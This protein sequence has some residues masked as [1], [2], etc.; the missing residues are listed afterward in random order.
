MEHIEFP[1]I[2]RLNREIVVTEK[3]DGTNGCILVEPAQNPLGYPTGFEESMSVAKVGNLYVYAGSKSRWIVPGDD[4]YG[5]AAWVK[6]N[7][8]EL[9]PKLGPGLHYGEWWGHGIQRGYGLPKGERR[10]S[11]F[12]T[13][14]WNDDEARPKCCSVVP[15][16]YQGPLD[17]LRIYSAEEDLRE[18]GSFAAPGFAD[19]E[20]YV[21]F[22]TAANICFKVTL[23]G[24]EAGKSYENH[25]KKERQPRAPRDPATGGRRKAQVEIAFADRRKK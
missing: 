7:A 9:A 3:I 22:H 13:H 14:R 21:V 24:D 25:P 16:L 6:E 23:K 18:R 20:G 19:P 5:F 4:N 11:L 2:A 10:F 15:T 8:E 12:N 17:F 1:K